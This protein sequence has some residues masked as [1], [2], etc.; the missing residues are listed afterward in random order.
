MVKVG[1]IGAT[2]YTGE[3]LIK[4][5]LRHPQ[6]R[7]TYLSAKID[8]EDN[9]D[10]I[11]PYLKSRLDLKCEILDIRKAIKKSD[12]FFLAVPHTVSCKIAPLLL[13]H[14][15]R[16]ID[17]SADYRLKNIDTYEQWYKIKHSDKINVKKSVY[18]LPEL[19]REK[20]KKAD[21]IANPGCYP[22]V[23]ILAIAPLIVSG[24][25][26][27][28]SVIIDAKSGLTGAGR[29]ASLDF[30]FSEINENCKPY[31]LNCHQHMP[32]IEQEL[33]MLLGKKISVSFC[34]HIVPMNRGIVETIYAR[35][36]K[37]LSK[38]EM[39]KVYTR[40]FKKEPFVRI[41]E[42]G[43]PTVRNVV[44]TNFCDIGV[45]LDTK[46]GVLIVVSAIDNLLKGAAG[47]AV[48]NMNIMFGFPEASG[49]L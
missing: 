42:E 48:Q 24:A 9:I 4:I 38:S 3:E 28:K 25:I 11:F 32:E 29:K 36:K 20:I 17:L 30:F 19:Y 7:I 1:I 26:D 8:K 40:F 43:I 16:V 34:P 15:K 33:S 31:K 37:S 6:V 5:L 45:Q 39:L 49:L 13:K 12:L 22:T 23:A 14:N 21:L 44:Q 18:G 10:E 47:Q 41:L 2:G 35:P 27:S 46:R